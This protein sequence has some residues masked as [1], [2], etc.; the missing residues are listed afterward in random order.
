MIYK[1][2]SYINKHRNI[3]LVPAVRVAFSRHQLFS[4]CHL[5]AAWP[6]KQTPSRLRLAVQPEIPSEMDGN[7]F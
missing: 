3:L 2:I 7:G 6:Q 4:R 5:L 1:H